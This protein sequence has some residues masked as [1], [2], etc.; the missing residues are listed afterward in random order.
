MGMGG[1]Q[2]MG[3]LCGMSGKLVTALVFFLMQSYLHLYEAGS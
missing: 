1:V 3:Y 2:G